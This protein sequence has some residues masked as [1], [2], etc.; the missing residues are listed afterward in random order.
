MIA[1]WRKSSKLIS[2]ASECIVCIPFNTRPT[3]IWPVL[4][5]MQSFKEEQRSSAWRTCRKRKIAFLRLAAENLVTSLKWRWSFHGSRFLGSMGPYS[6]MEW[7]SRHSTWRFWI[8]AEDWATFC[9]EELCISISTESIGPKKCSG[10]HN[11]DGEMVRWMSLLSC[12][13]DD[14]IISISSNPIEHRVHNRVSAS[15]CSAY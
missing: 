9:A 15:W 8:K 3:V 6:A 14:S 1:N 12:L 5:I 4:L 10:S 11:L 7:I 2:I 13:F